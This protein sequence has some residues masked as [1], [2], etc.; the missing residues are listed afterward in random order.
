MER[1]SWHENFLA[2]WDDDGHDPLVAWCG[3][4]ILPLQ[5]SMAVGPDGGGLASLVILVKKL[6]RGLCTAPRAVAA[7][8]ACRRDCICLRISRRYSPEPL[9]QV[10]HNLGE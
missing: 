7:D 5:S 10:I 9:I 6:V 2:W 1:L 4:G 8:L 3:W